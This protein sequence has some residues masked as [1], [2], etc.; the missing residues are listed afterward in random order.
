[1]NDVIIFLEKQVDVSKLHA[2]EVFGR[3]GDWHTTVYANKVK[4]LQVWE[5]DKK[6]KNKI[7]WFSKRKNSGRLFTYS[8]IF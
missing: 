6:W 5:I 8:S 3:G 1:M 2:L 4:S 7:Y